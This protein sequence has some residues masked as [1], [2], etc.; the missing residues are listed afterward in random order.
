MFHFHQKFPLGKKT[1]VSFPMEECIP[2]FL[3]NCI[4]FLEGK[5]GRCIGVVSVH[6]EVFSGYT[7]SKTMFSMVVFVIFCT[8]VGDLHGNTCYATVATI[9]KMC[10][11]IFIYIYIYMYNN[12]SL[13]VKSVAINE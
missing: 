2:S 9:Y 3:T 7:L 13:V 1:L 8:C 12:T 6:A 5:V 4:S 11:Y 10:V